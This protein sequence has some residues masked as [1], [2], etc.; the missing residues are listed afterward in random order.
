[1]I[2]FCIRQII[3]CKKSLRHCYSTNHYSQHYS[4][5]SHLM[6]NLHSCL[7]H[8]CYQSTYYS[9]TP[10]RIKIHH[11]CEFCCYAIFFTMFQISFCSP[12]KTIRSLN[13]KQAK[14][15]I[16]YKPQSL[17]RISS[18]VRQAVTG[19]VQNYNNFLTCV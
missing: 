12:K 2:Y 6:S 18:P 17:I 4:I 16:L 13:I 15:Y 7:E 5:P 19:H 9:S 1:M 11:E 10:W 3:K 14:Y 8:G